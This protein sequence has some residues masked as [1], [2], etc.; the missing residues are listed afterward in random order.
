MCVDRRAGVLLNRLFEHAQRLEV[1][2]VGR[3]VE[4]DHVGG[5]AQHFRQQHAVAH[6]A[7]A[8]TQ[9]LLLV[10]A[11]EVEARHV[12][13]SV[14]NLVAEGDLRVAFGDVVVHRLRVVEHRA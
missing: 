9:Q 8:L 7:R 13:A 1:E 4:Q 11:L 12:G 10:L 6:A 3:F 5:L 2:I 14:Q